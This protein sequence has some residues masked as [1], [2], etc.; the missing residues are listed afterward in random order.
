MHHDRLLLFVGPPADSQL[1]FDEVRVHL[2]FG[3]EH[4]WL[5]VEFTH[6]LSD[7]L[8]THFVFCFFHSLARVPQ[9]L[10]NRI[11]WFLCLLFFLLF[12]LNFLY[13]F[14]ARL[15]I[16]AF[17]SFGQLLFPVFF[18]STIW[19]LNLCL[20][21]QFL[22]QNVMDLFWYIINLRLIDFLFFAFRQWELLFESFLSHVFSETRNCFF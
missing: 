7:D 19:Q 13:A 21:S 9:K 8:R 2:D 17:N 14:Q 18:L 20:F 3:I 6:L 1:L 5:A 22:W 15:R 12:L 16:R 11:K 10:L 4:G